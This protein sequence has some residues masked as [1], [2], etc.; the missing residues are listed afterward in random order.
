MKTNFF[1]WKQRNPVGLAVLGLVGVVSLSV[2]SPSHG[3]NQKASQGAGGPVDIIDWAG[4]IA[5]DPAKAPS[6]EIYFSPRRGAAPRIVDAKT[7]PSSPFPDGH[8]AVYIGKDDDSEGPSSEGQQTNLTM[9]LNPFFGGGEPPL[10]GWL[11]A[12]FSIDSGILTFAMKA[13]AEEPSPNESV[14][15]GSQGKE[16]QLFKAYIQPDNTILIEHGSPGKEN[17]E[18]G[19]GQVSVTSGVPHVFRVEWDWSGEQLL[20]QFLLD[21]E[22]MPISQSNDTLVLDRSSQAKAINRLDCSLPAG[23]FLGRVTVSE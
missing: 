15:R 11:Q 19:R 10:K 3:E 21:G 23:S 18:K 12:E 1:L 14:A 20:L 22:L 5:G 16:Q 9:I 2:L 17:Q 4:Q 7:D 6:P 13:D 8:L